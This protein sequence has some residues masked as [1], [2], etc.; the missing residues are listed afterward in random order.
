MKHEL[1]T[2]TDGREIAFDEATQNVI[3]HGPEGS[4]AILSYGDM[5]ALRDYFEKAVDQT[6]SAD[7]VRADL[8]RIIRENDTTDMTDDWSINDPSD[9][10]EEILAAYRLTPKGARKGQGGASCPEDCICNVYPDCPD[11]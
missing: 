2:H 9:A 5:E 11:R 4:T 1:Y 8:W 6:A 10:V 7:D 3:I